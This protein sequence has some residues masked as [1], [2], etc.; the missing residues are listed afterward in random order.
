MPD[1][2]Y[3]K[4]QY[5]ATW[6]ASSSR[7]AAVAASIEAATGL[8]VV[9]VGLGAGSS[10]FLSGPAAARGL[11]KGDADLAVK[12][13]SIRLEV[14]GP[15]VASVDRSQPLWVRPDKLANARRNATHEV[16]II[17]HLPKD[18]LLRVIPLDA[19]FWQSLDAGEFPTVT[20]TI[21]GVLERYHSI[22]AAHACVRP[23]TDLIARLKLIRPA[24]RQ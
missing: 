24:D 20:P 12:D 15:L 16:W 21:R 7:E 22:P 3:W 9:P 17:H 5:Q 14:T 13:T 18:N 11:E 10:E 2:D 8:K 4:K 23:F 6:A 19:R 1:F